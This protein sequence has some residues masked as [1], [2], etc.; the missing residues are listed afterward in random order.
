M[1]MSICGIDCGQCPL[2]GE[3]CGCVASNGR[4]F[5]GECMVARCC[6][7]KGFA[8]CTECVDSTCTLQQQA[9]AELNALGIADM[10]KIMSL[11]QLRGAFVNLEYALPGGQVAKFLDDDRIYL[12][13]QVQK[14]GSDRCYGVIVE[15]RYLL[16][17]EYGEGGAD[18][19]IVVYQRRVK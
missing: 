9:I 14:I 8:R 13:T 11:N 5:G 7:D 10:E 18:V 3:C 4:P 19:E 2:Q 16:V 12:G 6:R 15:D 17:C 1:G